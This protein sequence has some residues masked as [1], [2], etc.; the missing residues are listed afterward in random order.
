[1]D[2]MTKKP[3]GIL[4][5][6]EEYIQQYV[7]LASPDYAFAAALWAVGTYL[8]PHFDAFPYLVITSDV[9]RSG[10]SRFGEVL[11]FVASNPRSFA[12]MT[13]ATLFRSIRDENPTVFIDE[14]ET[15]SSEAANTM[16][17]VLNVG[18][19]RGQSIPRMEKGGVREWPVYCPKVF[20]LIGDVYDTLR[21]RSII[22]RMQRGEPATRFVYNQAHAEGAAL[23]ERI[24]SIVEEQAHVFQGRYNRHAGVPFLPDRDEEIWLP[25]FVICEELAPN[26]VKELQRVAADLAVEKTQESRRYVNLL[27]AEREAEDD[28]FARRLVRD[29]L[30][31]MNGAKRIHTQDAIE[32]LHAL[33]T[34]PWRKFRG[35]GLTATDM[36][37]LLAR[38]GIKPTTIRIGGKKADAKVAK[39][40]KVEH[41][42]A[43]VK[44]LG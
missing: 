33:P 3:D 13:P 35:E 16:R 14:A 2:S 44:A 20:I 12:G 8:W 21:D 19:R 42:T 26:R 37:N 9:K 18:Y 17:A 28:E 39:G 5:E 11:S 43:A 7:T 10:K 41:V 38:F 4:R 29:L 23:R 25:L 24:A 30:V 1:M 40:Y 15:L 27:G 22:V 31:V 34:G 36:S 6:L 32:K